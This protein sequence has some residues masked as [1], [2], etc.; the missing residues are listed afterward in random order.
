MDGL[1]LSNASSKSTIYI[2]QN[3][4]VKGL[5]RMSYSIFYD[6]PPHRLN[7]FTNS[8]RDQIQDLSTKVIDYEDIT[9][10]NPF[11]TKIEFT[12]LQDNVISKCSYCHKILDV[13]NL[14]TFAC[15]HQSCNECCEKLEEKKICNFDGI[16]IW[17]V[18]YYSV[19]S[20]DYKRFYEV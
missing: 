9:I 7:A 10:V 11:N 14:H 16:K 1:C 17:K 12:K 4:S 8:E 20:D 6:T 2:S 15:L 5:R 3:T 19:G 13:K 18:V